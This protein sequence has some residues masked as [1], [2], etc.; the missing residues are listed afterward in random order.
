M[1][2]VKRTP[3]KL[4]NLV[5]SFELEIINKGADFDTREITIPDVNR[6]ALQLVGFY[7]YFEPRR[8]QIL[9]K[10]E[11]TYLNAMDER[12]RIVALD[13]L[14]RCELPALIVSHNMEVLPELVELAQK[15]GRTL[16]RTSL[17]TVNLTSHIIDY[18]NRALAPQIVRHGVLMNIYGQGVLI[19]GDSGIGK[20]E[21]AIELLKRGHRLVADDAVEIRQV[22]NNLYGTAP[23]IIRHYVEIRGVGI[24]EVQK[25]FGMGAVQFETEI[26]LVIQLEQWVE[27]KFYDR[28]GLGEDS[29]TMLGVSLPYVTI[30]VR[31]GRNLAGIVEIA[32]M[33]N[34][35][36][37][38]GENSAYDFVMQFDQKVD[39]MT[40]KAR[41]NG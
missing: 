36:M 21:T 32:T 40:R 34:R 38:Y 25:L 12:E 23:E 35:Q 27:G 37:K 19:L 39:E 26:D 4:S 9:G 24:I 20:S 22:S 28:L 41:E 8:L 29:Y 30:P 5:E 33:K 1:E 15:H 11:M 31:P 13:N 18:L 17:Q 14:M 6:P 7:D 2:K 3:A 10:A 16:L